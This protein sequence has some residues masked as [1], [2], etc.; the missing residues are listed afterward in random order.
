MMQSVADTLTAEWKD[1]GTKV[2]ALTDYH[3]GRNSVQ[4][5]VNAAIAQLRALQR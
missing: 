3:S 4:A 2:V 1:S 5:K